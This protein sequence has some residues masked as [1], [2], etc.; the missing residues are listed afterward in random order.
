MPVY[1]AGAKCG[2]AKHSHAT[3]KSCKLALDLLTIL[4]A[5]TVNLDFNNGNRKFTSLTHT[6]LFTPSFP[7]PSQPAYLFAYSFL[8][9]GQFEQNRREEF[10][11]NVL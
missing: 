1:T 6:H 8:G 9:A 5:H 10:R 11:Y 2:C 4:K 7:P 3:F